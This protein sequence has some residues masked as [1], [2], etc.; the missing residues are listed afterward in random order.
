LEPH[1]YLL[2]ALKLAEQHRGFCAPNP[3]VGAVFVQ[4]DSIIS[5]G[6]HAGPGFAHAEVIAYQ[7]L[8]HPVD[9]LVLY[10][11][12]EPCCHWGRTP[13]CTDFIVKKGIKKVFYAFKDPNPKVAG[14][15]ER[16]LTDN[17]VYCQQISLPEINDFYESYSFWT[18]TQ[19]PWVTCKLAMSLDGKIADAN[20]NPLDITGEM[21][22]RYTHEWRMRSDA[23]LTS[24]KTIIQ[25]N[26]ALNVRLSDK[27]IA[28][29]LYIL[30]S[31]L[32]LPL[33]AQVLTT[34]AKITVFHSQ[35]NKAKID[36]LKDRKV[37][38]HRIFPQE[39]GPTLLEEVTKIIGAEGVHDL[40]VEAGGRVFNS[41]I[42]EGL[43]HR[44][45]IYI[46]PKLLGANA[47][48]AFLG[49]LNIVKQA[50]RVNWHNKGQDGICEINWV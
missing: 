17:G 41:L 2:E 4:N 43:A 28:K 45:L 8:S 1:Y 49:E 48:P 20:G 24:A 36:K 32:S 46:A 47:Y 42:M 39:G 19:K 9:D 16:F 44:S 5:T 34:A 30:D 27:F 35:E 23:L 26:P 7:N 15:G 3:S 22:R 6:N 38:C 33:D 37:N 18:Q 40:W 21:A 12:L 11:T 10:V 31:T 25:D 29:P 14:K 13:P 50:R